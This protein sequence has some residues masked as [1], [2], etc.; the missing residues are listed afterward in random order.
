MIK[1]YSVEC[2][3]RIVQLSLISLVFKFIVFKNSFLL[4]NDSDLVTAC[5]SKCNL[6]GICVVP[7]IAPS[8]S[9]Q[10]IDVWSF[11]AAVSD[12]PVKEA[13]SKSS[14]SGEIE[15]GSSAAQ[16]DSIFTKEI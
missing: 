4:N 11:S 6:K 12:S 3:E 9:L 2:V 8:Q 15:S 13:P 14:T 5:F 7:S 10:A 1:S 16:A